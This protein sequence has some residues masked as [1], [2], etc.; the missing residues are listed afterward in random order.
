M[1]SKSKL[2]DLQK[3]FMKCSDDIDE[4]EIE[5]RNNNNNI[6]DT[7]ELNRL[8]IRIDKINQEFSQLL[9]IVNRSNNQKL[10]DEFGEFSNGIKKQIKVLIEAIEKSIDSISKHEHEQHHDEEK[11]SATTTSLE[12]VEKQNFIDSNNDDKCS[13]GLIHNHV[14]HNRDDS[15]Q[16]EICRC[17]FCWRKN[18]DLL[19]KDQDD[20]WRINVRNFF[21]QYQDLTTVRF[22]CRFRE[23]RL[24]LFINL[25]MDERLRL[26]RWMF[27]LLIIEFYEQIDHLVEPIVKIASMLKIDNWNHTIM[28]WLR[29]RIESGIYSDVCDYEKLHGQIDQ[30]SDIIREQFELNKQKSLN[31]YWNTIYLIIVMFDRNVINFNPNDSMDFLLRILKFL[32]QNSQSDHHPEIYL[33][34]L[35]DSLGISAPKLLISIKKARMEFKIKEFFTEI[36]HVLLQTTLISNKDERITTIL[37]MI[38]D[39]LDGFTQQKKRNRYEMKSLK[40]Y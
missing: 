13:N 19:A 23:A 9:S 12:K 21:R 7:S 4:I 22:L 27:E 20:W 29:E 3:K 5:Y 8:L 11:P 39:N 35:I 17:W 34:L 1:G 31:H 37:E 25:S 2:F 24:N 14:D 16:T 33:D 28:E 10:F 40:G 18:P 32:L 26:I 38:E 30:Y 36:Q 6:N 15:K